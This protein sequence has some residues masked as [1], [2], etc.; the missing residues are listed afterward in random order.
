MALFFCNTFSN[1]KL[2]QNYSAYQYQ[3][4]GKQAHRFRPGEPVSGGPQWHAS[5]QQSGSFDADGETG[6]RGD[7]RWQGRQGG[8]LGGEYR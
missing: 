5:L 3:N 1:I 4:L 6:G 7:P 2:S 8:D